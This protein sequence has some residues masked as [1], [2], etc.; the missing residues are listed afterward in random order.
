MENTTAKNL[1]KFTRPVERA[2]AINVASPVTGK[3]VDALKGIGQALSKLNGAEL[4][5]ALGIA[6][7]CLLGIITVASGYELEWSGEYGDASA[8]VLLRKER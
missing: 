7:I 8:R 4:V 6:G 3:L 2:T 1:D 5:T